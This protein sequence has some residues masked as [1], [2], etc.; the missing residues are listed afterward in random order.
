[1]RKIAL[2]V[3]FSAGLALSA[4]ASAATPT[5]SFVGTWVITQGSM[6][7]DGTP[8]PFEVFSIPEF[9]HVDPGNE[10]RAVS[11]LFHPASIGTVWQ[12]VDGRSLT[13]PVNAGTGIG[14]W[15]RA[16]RGEVV[17]SYHSFLFDAS[18]KPIGYLHALRTIEAPLPEPP[19]PYD[20][21]PG[22]STQKD[23]IQAGSATDVL[24][25]MAYVRFFDLAGQPLALPIVTGGEPVYGLA[26]PYRAVRAATAEL[27]R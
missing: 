17:L 6:M 4:T 16:S 22:S 15:W 27:P 24:T 14:D 21:M 3:L 19:P 11:G 8:I 26:G 25:G 13:V 10:I 2:A 7:A 20:L 23:E 18:N 12:V 1:M 5:P 9:M